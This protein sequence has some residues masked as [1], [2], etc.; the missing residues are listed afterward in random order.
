MV[1]SVMLYGPNS[2]PNSTQTLRMWLLIEIMKNMDKGLT[3]HTKMGADSSAENTPNAPEFKDL[4]IEN[5][6]KHISNE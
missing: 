1:K 4:F 3:T 2:N 5:C 6:S